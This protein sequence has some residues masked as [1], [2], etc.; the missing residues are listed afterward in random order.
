MKFQLVLLL[1]ALSNLV[2]AQN[3]IVNP[4]C[5]LPLVN[6]KIPSWTEVL[7]NEWTN[8]SSTIS[9]QHGQSFFYAG[10]VP[11]AELAQT[12]VLNDYTCAI[13]QGSQSFQF[14]AYVKS[15]S[16]NPPDQSL[17]II[18]MLNASDAVLKSQRFG[19]YTTTGWSPVAELITIPA[20]TRK[21]KIRLLSHRVTGT[22]N[23]GYFDN[24]SLTAIATN[25]GLKIE[26]V[27][28]LSAGCNLTNGALSFTASGGSGQYTYSLDGNTFQI[29]PYFGNLAPGDYTLMVKDGG[30]TASQV[31]TV[32]TTSLPHIDHVQTANATCNQVTGALSLTVSGGS[33]NKQYSLDGKTFQILPI[34]LNLASG[35]YTVTVKDGGCIASQGATVGVTNAPHIDNVQVANANCNQ[36]N[37]ALSLTVSGGSGTSQYALDGKTFQVL[38]TFLNLASGDYTV[39]IKDGGCLLSQTATV[40][41]SNPP[42]VDQ[43]LIADANCNKTDGALSLT[44]VGG[45]G[46][47]Q[48]ALDGKTFQ[49]LPIFLNLASGNYTVT[50]K[51]GN[52]LISQTATVGTKSPPHIDRVQVADASCG[53]ANGSVM[54]LVSGGT[55][56]YSYS[57]DGQSFQSGKTFNSLAA[58]VYILT[59][60]DGACTAT[61]SATIADINTLKIDRLEPTDASCGQANGAISIGASGGSGKY[62]Y[63]LDGQ[64]FQ[65][66]YTFTNL[67]GGTYTLTVKDGGCIQ[68]QSFSLTTT[69]TPVIDFVP[70]SD[71]SCNLSNGALTISAD[72]GN[73]GYT[74]SIDGQSFQSSAAFTNLSGGTYTVMVQDAAGC[75]GKKEVTILVVDDCPVYVPDAFSPNNDGVNDYFRFYSSQ[76]TTYTIRKLVIY[77]R[78]GDVIFS[79]ENFSIMEP[80][81]VW[82]DGTF[83]GE[84]VD[85]GAYSYSF[86]YIDSKN[87]LNAR[88][89][90]VMVIR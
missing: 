11:D 21:L 37:G 25:Q 73:G 86:D 61:Q 80:D 72:G 3:L 38:P 2:N 9:A 6:G 62:A 17:I 1:V 48:Y 40:G 26:S 70:T 78:W 77:N 90:I 89:G 32:A 7:G 31:A 85:P 79:K 84:K 75:I 42:R 4:D 14:N 12:I 53:Q 15:Y 58:G 52:C 44:V 54:A 71:A 20:K 35:D 50:I 49:I 56:Q 19:P 5:E 57:I 13:D 69:D 65:N 51:D 87:K 23:D 82:W 81:N 30:C 64:P 55:N 10:D 60:K 88:R 74:Y 36:A 27:S 18:E 41:V 24:L 22:H 59:V 16:E 46:A 28:S 66:S 76:T 68:S 67:K 83:K 34:F 45:S 39:T 33:G 47:S 29:T 8:G 63:S 43:V